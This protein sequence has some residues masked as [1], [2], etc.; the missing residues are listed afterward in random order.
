M[1]TQGARGLSRRSPGP[2]RWAA[3]VSKH[4]QVRRGHATWRD[5]QPPR[6][7]GDRCTVV[8]R[9]EP[10]ARCRTPASP[11]AGS[12]RWSIGLCDGD[13]PSAS[14]VRLAAAAAVSFFYDGDCVCVGGDVERSRISP[15][16]AKPVAAGRSAQSGR[17]VAVESRRLS[18]A[19]VAKRLRQTGKQLVALPSCTLAGLTSRPQSCPSSSCM[20]TRSSASITHGRLIGVCACSAAEPPE[21]LAAQPRR[22]RPWQHR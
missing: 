9:C 1:G 3:L 17:R 8:L 2:V 21:A 7:L 11:A 12:V 6:W 20:S 13:L 14:V 19:A 4:V 15:C 18:A 22:R 10:R 16:P 5:K